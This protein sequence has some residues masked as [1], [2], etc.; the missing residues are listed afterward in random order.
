[1]RSPVAVAGLVCGWVLLAVCC[2][3]RAEAERWCFWNGRLPRVT[4]YAHTCAA[5]VRGDTRALLPR[6]LVV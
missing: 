4:R 2:Q 1:M 5:R 6:S 3:V